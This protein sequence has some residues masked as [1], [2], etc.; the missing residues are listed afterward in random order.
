MVN[1]YIVKAQKILYRTVYTR[2]KIIKMMDLDWTD[3][4]SSISQ[5]GTTSLG[6]AAW[7]GHLDVV[8]YLHENGANVNAVATVSIK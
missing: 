8:R 2:Y 5:G 6:L 1:E 3:N 4:D 7:Q